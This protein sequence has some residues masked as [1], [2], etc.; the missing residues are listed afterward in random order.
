MKKGTLTLFYRRLIRLQSSPW[1]P[2]R[3][4]R[5]YRETHPHA[6]GFPRVQ[7]LKWLED[8]FQVSGVD[9]RPIVANGEEPLLGLL[10]PLNLSSAVTWMRSELGPPY[11]ACVVEQNLENAIAGRSGLPDTQVRSPHVTSGSALPFPDSVLL[12]RIEATTSIRTDWNDASS[13]CNATGQNRQN[14]S[15]K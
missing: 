11:A 12:K 13:T 5:A 10:R 3:M 15:A 6:R 9:S 2:T 4:A 8:A 7:S 1:L 14:A